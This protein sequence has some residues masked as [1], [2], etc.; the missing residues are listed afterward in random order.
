MPPYSLSPYIDSVI[1]SDD[2]FGLGEAS[3][4]PTLTRASDSEQYGFGQPAAYRTNI[5]LLE[6]QREASENKAMELLKR[7]MQNSAEV[8]PTQGIAAA[9]LAAIPTFGGYMIGKSVGR[10]DLPAGYFEAGGTRA[11]LGDTSGIGAGPGGLAGAQAGLAAGGGYLKGLE[12]DK[13]QENKVLQAQAQIEASKAARLQGRADALTQAGLAQQAEI[14]QIPLREASQMRLQN[15]S[16][17]NTMERQLELQRRSNDQE[18]LSPAILAKAQEAL[19]IPQDP[20]MTTD[21]LRAV[22]NAVAEQRRDQGQDIRLSGGAYIP[23]SPP[24]KAAMT[25]ILKTK[26]IGT[27]YINELSAIGAQDPSLLTRTIESVLPQTALGKLGKDLELFAVQIRNARENGVMTQQD[28]ERYNSYLSI[29]PLDTVQSVLERMKEL[30]TVTD[31]SA[32]AVLTSA[33]LGQENV[34]NYRKLF[35]KMQTP[36]E[37]SLPGSIQLQAQGQGTTGDLMGQTS[38]QD[39]QLQQ[40]GFQVKPKREQYSSDSEYMNA[41]EQYIIS[42]RGSKR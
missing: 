8:T 14:D 38:P 28:F 36:G 42:K 5:A 3:Y 30:Q 18:R 33:E 34:S 37:S 35:P 6:S 12:A 29:T 25:D 27:R 2:P 4:E 7:S 16:A 17:Q 40:Q 31:L 22:T 41:L 26:S 20:N 23:P 11:A 39:G 10:P 32:E 21:Q 13:A 19:G 1:A 9:L 24:T 15:N